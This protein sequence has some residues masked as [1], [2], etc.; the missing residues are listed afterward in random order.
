MHRRSS[1]RRTD[2]LKKHLES[3]SCSFS[4]LHKY[5]ENR[6]VERHEAVT[7]FSEAL[8]DVVESLEELM[9]SET[10]RNATASA[11]HS[12]LR[13]FNFLVSLAYL[14]G[15]FVDISVVLEHI[16]LVLKELGNIRE[17]AHDQFKEIFNHVKERRKDS[18]FSQRFQ[19]K[20]T[21]YSL[22]LVLPNYAAHSSF[23]SLQPAVEFYMADLE[24]KNLRE[25]PY[26]CVGQRGVDLE[27]ARSEDGVASTVAQPNA[28]PDFLADSL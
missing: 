19:E 14:Q 27:L 12:R 13:S 2:V 5:C 15:N 4:R 17:D 1:S 11:L 28:K 25:Q 6:W 21:L 8:P 22:Q 10:G 26:W 20:A 7:L 3:S 24:P 9:E 16:D 23:E 18:V